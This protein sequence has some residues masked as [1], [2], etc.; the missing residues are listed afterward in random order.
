VIKTASFGELTLMIRW[1]TILCIVGCSSGDLIVGAHGST[2]KACPDVQTDFDPSNCGS[3][4]HVC[5]AASP[6]CVDGAC[7][8]TPRRFLIAGG[9]LTTCAIRKQT[10]VCWGSNGASEFAQPTPMASA[11]AIPTSVTDVR[12][13]AMSDY[14][15]CVIRTSGDL[16]CWGWNSNGQIG[17]GTTTD[18]PSPVR[19][20]LTNVL[21]VS[22]GTT[23]TCAMTAAD[24]FCWGGSTNTSPASVNI[25]NVRDISTGG[26][27]TCVVL[28]DGSVQCWGQ[29]PLAAVKGVTNAVQVAVA[30]RDYACAILSDRRVTCWSLVSASPSDQLGDGSI[31]DAGDLCAGIAYAC[32]LTA[33]HSVKCWGTN[34][35]GTLGAGQGTG[36]SS[37]APVTP[38]SDSAVAIG[39]GQHHACALLSTG[40]M[41]CWG[42]N[43][44]GQLGD[45]TQTT[46]NAPVK[47]QGF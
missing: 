20:N 33:A 6:Y 10:L 36:F 13:V 37:A 15:P 47:V 5:G 23:R 43:L 39:C 44:T 30:Y 24:A 7:A 11:I 12:A 27:N 40:T 3:C 42:N 31:T 4:G 16:D 2:A 1:T 21:E 26:V 45:G 9:S 29:S 22:A 14:T 28:G 46:R 34:Q 19:V 17:N 35:F 38:I 25:P 18:S 8:A 32:A 41:L